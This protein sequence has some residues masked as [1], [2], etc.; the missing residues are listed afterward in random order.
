MVCGRVRDVIELLKQILIL[1]SDKFP[2]FKGV[3]T[4]VVGSLK[5][6]TKI[7]DIDE[8]DIVLAL[9]EDF[10]QDQLNYDEEQQK[11]VVR[12]FVF[13]RV[14]K[15]AKKQNL[16]LPEELRPFVSRVTNTAEFYGHIDTNKYFFTFMEEFHK[17]IQSGR[18]EL[19]RGLS[20][21]TQFIPCRVCKNTD[22][23][24]EQY[25]RCKHEP[26]CQ[27]HLRQG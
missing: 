19:P 12:K 27:E 4:I 6:Q 10:N 1:M 16:L 13:D 17:I 7:G 20:L 14:G 8:A 15:F 11:I 22:Y 9:S 18:L 3:S 2:I 21:S 25:V 5:E 26:G 24:V 23:T